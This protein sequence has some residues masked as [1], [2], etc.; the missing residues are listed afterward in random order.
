MEPLRGPGEGGWVRGGHG[1]QDHQGR[2][3][4]SGAGDQGK[5][6]DVR[7]RNRAIPVMCVLRLHRGGN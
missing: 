3:G 7:A 6:G 4:G 1:G 2:G 5:Q